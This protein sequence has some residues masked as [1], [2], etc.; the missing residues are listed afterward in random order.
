MFKTTSNLVAVAVI[1]TLPTF[2]AAQ[3]TAVGLS[4]SLDDGDVTSVSVAAA[5]GDFAVASSVATTNGTGAA[6]GASDDADATPS[7]AVTYNGD[8][9][10][11]ETN[12]A[13]D[14]TVEE[15]NELIIIPD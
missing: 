7:V 3:S 6:S 1:A 4:A 14:V 8:A 13:F 9:S 11:Y 12:V 15:E 10:A 2:A 5:F